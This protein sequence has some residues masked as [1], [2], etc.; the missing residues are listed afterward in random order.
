MAV[1]ELKDVY[2]DLDEVMQ[3]PEVKVSTSDNGKSI[4]GD[5]IV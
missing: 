5:N 4:D 2:K 1:K 3:L